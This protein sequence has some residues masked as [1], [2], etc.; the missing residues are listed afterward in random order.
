MPEVDCVTLGIPG[1]EGPLPRLASER[2][3]LKEE[4]TDACVIPSR[5][6]SPPSAVVIK[7]PMQG[8]ASLFGPGVLGVRL[9]GPLSC[10]LTALPH[11][12][13][14]LRTQKHSAHEL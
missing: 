5:E 10:V 9:M 2:A 11:L 1:E 12:D 13:E 6:A 7:G 14:T 4:P 8:G 3:S